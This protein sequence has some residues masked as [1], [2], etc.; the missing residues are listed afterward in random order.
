MAIA[1]ELAKRIVWMQ[2]EDLPA[3][4]IEGF[5]NRVCAIR[6]K[7]GKFDEGRR[8]IPFAQMRGDS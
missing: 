7:D 4:G 5:C 1:Q 3:E 8:S 2:Y 6:S